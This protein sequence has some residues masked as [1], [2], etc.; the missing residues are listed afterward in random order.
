[1]F[2]RGIGCVDDFVDAGLIE[3]FESVVPLE[4]FEVRPDGSLGA[5]LSGLFAG[6]RRL[7][8]ATARFAPDSLPTALLP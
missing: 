3:S 7:S 6:N 5:E 4:V 8:S 2:L 1:M